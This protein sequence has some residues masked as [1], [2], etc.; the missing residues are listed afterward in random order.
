M[1]RHEPE[2]HLCTDDQDKGHF[3]SNITL[4]IE[5][6]EGPW[7]VAGFTKEGKSLQ[8]D[9]PVGPYAHFFVP[10]MCRL[11][12]ARQRRKAGAG[13]YLINLVAGDILI[14]AGVEHT[15]SV[16]EGRPHMDRLRRG[17][18]SS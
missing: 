14:L 4:V 17:L 9:G 2:L 5:G 8:A 15:V 16:V 12:T 13:G 10:P 18:T 7:N 11:G 3:Y 6:A 1:N